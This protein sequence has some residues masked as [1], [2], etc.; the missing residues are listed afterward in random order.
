MRLSVRGER[1]QKTSSELL[2]EAAYGVMTWAYGASE[3]H[4]VCSRPY[5]GTSCVPQSGTTNPV[6]SVG[7]RTPLYY[8]MSSNAIDMDQNVGYVF[9]IGVTP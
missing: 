4:G 9:N 3:G 2:R 5:G 6:D 8:W 1:L 7:D